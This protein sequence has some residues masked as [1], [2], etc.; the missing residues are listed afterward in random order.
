VAVPVYVDRARNITRLLATLGVRLTKL[1][2]S[3]ARPPRARSLDGPGDWQ[4]VEPDKHRT[5]SYLIPVDEFAEVELRGL[6]TLTRPE[7]RAVC[8]ARKTKEVIVAALQE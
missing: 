6:R 4:A 8:D 7:L 1:E 3:F 5:A 2:A